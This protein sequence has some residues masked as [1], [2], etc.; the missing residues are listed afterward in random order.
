MALIATLQPDVI[1]LIIENLDHDIESIINFNRLVCPAFKYV[2]KSCYENRISIIKDQLVS[3]I[4]TLLELRQEN[5]G[6]VDIL[7]A[8]KL[9]AIIASPIG[10]II[11]S[12]SGKFTSVAVNKIFELLSSQLVLGMTSS[13]NKQKFIRLLFN[14]LKN[15]IVIQKKDFLMQTIHAG[16]FTHCSDVS[17]ESFEDNYMYTT[18]TKEVDPTLIKYHN[19]TL[20]EILSK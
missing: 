10:C 20:S 16:Y 8:M 3:N 15:I 14:T 9:F 1:R 6:S 12:S 17:H 2:G 18:T 11:C 13:D 7:T 5:T 19:I 4:Q